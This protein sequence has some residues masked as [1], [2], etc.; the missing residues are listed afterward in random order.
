M[1]AWL[2][3]VW[4]QLLAA[5]LV[6]IGYILFWY[7]QHQKQRDYALHTIVGILLSFFVFSICWFSYLRNAIKAGSD[8]IAALE[9]QLARSN[10]FNPGTLDLVPLGTPV[11]RISKDGVAL[12]WKTCL[13]RMQHSWTATSYIKPEQGWNQAFTKEGLEIQRQKV[14]AG[15]MIKRVFIVDSQQELDSLKDVIRAQESA[16]I[17]VRWL[18]RQKIDTLSSLEA[19]SK[20][21]ET[22]D[23]VVADSSTLLLICIDE[24]RV[25]QR[26]EV[27][28]RPQQVNRYQEFH[29]LLWAES[30]PL[31]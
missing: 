20:N 27:C 3:S 29:D 25:I 4:P 24:K 6:I 22:F 8:G 2:T 9:R 13:S 14:F 31:P 5:T 30:N 12:L 10:P 11:V 21:L 18:S 23:F 26:A 7:F 16:G 19:A 1:S 15:A 17:T 28:D